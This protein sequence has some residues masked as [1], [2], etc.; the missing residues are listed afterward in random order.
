MASVL[1]LDLPSVP[2][3]CFI[4]EKDSAEYEKLG[5]EREIN[6]MITYIYSPFP[7]RLGN[8]AFGDVYLIRDTSGECCAVKVNRKGNAG[9]AYL[10]VNSKY[11]HNALMIDLLQ[12]LTS[13][14]TSTGRRRTW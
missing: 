6:K 1:N 12:C 8:G 5:I 11:S 2:L 9:S 4:V 7:R 10:T 13:L 3:L 14:R